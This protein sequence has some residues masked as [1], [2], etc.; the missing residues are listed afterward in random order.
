M[1]VDLSGEHGELLLPLEDL[2]SG[3]VLVLDFLGDRSKI[4]LR[5]RDDWDVKDLSSLC[6]SGGIACQSRKIE[7]MFLKFQLDVTLKENY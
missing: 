5:R 7:Q 4:H 6:Q 3:E 1:G 2:D